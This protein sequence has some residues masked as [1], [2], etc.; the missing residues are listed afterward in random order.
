[1]GHHITLCEIYRAVV[2]L[3]QSGIV[4]TPCAQNIFFPVQAFARACI[5][6]KSATGKGSRD[7]LVAGT[8]HF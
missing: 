6:R 4:T 8:G 3:G 1:M 5:P 7:F 2:I